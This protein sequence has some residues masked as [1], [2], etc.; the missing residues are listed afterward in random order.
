MDIV[1]KKHLYIV[2]KHLKKPHDID[3]KKHEIKQLRRN[4]ES[5]KI[6]KDY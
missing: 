5:R 4:F 1:K 6:N 2:W 3:T